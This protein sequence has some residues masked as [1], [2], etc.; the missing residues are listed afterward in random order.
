MELHIPDGINYECTGCGKCCS[1]WSVPLTQDDYERISAYDWAEIDHDFKDKNLF[2]ELKTLEKLNTPYS[3]AINPNTNGQCPFLKNNLCFIHS[4]FGAAVKPAICKLFPYSF[5]ETP[6]GVFATVSFISRGAILNA[7]RPLLDQMEY[8]QSK[9][10]EFQSLFPSHHPNWTTIKLSSNIPLIWSD[11]LK[12]EEQIFGL[13]KDKSKNLE[14]RFIEGSHYLQSL[15]V[16]GQ[17]NLNE[18][19]NKLPKDNLSANSDSLNKWDQIIFIALYKK[20][21]PNKIGGGKGYGQVSL[22]LATFIKASFNHKEAEFLINES[23]QI[24]NFGNDPITDVIYRFFYSRLFAKLYFGAGFGQLSL[25]A[26]FNHLALCLALLKIKMKENAKARGE[27]KITIDDAISA[28][29]Q[30]EKSLGELKIS[31]Y[32]AAIMELL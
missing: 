19:A 30:L 29:V 7:G 1:G 13:I 4:K 8:L 22:D 14:E 15:L 5:N 10:S 26:G 11:Y 32:G 31:P 2:R 17:Q 18:P 12:I 9:Y 21:F 16:H 20:Y 27:E 3:H 25:I 23:K 24:S 28:I 6:S